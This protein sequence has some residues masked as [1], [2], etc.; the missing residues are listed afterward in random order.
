MDHIYLDNNASTYLLPSVRDELRRVIDGCYANPSSPHSGAHDGR[1]LIAN[2]RSNVAALVGADE[3]DIIFT[4]SGSDANAIVLNTVAH[5]AGASGRDTVLLSS[6]E[7]ASVYAWIDMFE[8]RGMTVHVLPVTRDGRI[9]VEAA[10]K[11]LSDRVHLVSVQWVNN[12]TGVIQPVQELAELAHEVGALFHTDAAQAVGRLPVDFPRAPFDFATFTGHKIHAPK[13]IG[14]LYAKSIDA[15]I[16]LVPGGEQ[17]HGI[18]AGTENFLNIVGLGG[19]ARERYEAM[20]SATK[21]MAECRDTFEST[22]TSEAPEIQINGDR[23]HRVPNTSNL[24][25]PKCDGHALIAQFDDAGVQCSQSSACTTNRPEPSRVLTAMGFNE[26]QAYA[27]IRFSFS[28]L[29]TIDEA[30]EAARRVI[31]T[32]ERVRKLSAMFA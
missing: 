26:D 3:D 20:E 18:R 16:P 17:E 19:A 31:E 6:I 23:E 15:L 24:Y 29:N 25:F 27:S 1:E 11:L 22:I 12:E 28:V 9:D 7:H 4:A 14:A 2:A 30:K 32:Y 5:D 13:G 21:H 10:R 8:Q